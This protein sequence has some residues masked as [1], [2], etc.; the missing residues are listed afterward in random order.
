MPHDHTVPWPA[1]PTHPSNTN[2]RCRL[3]HLVKTFWPGWTD[4]QRPGGTLLIGT[5]SGHTYA[6]KPG[7]ALLF[8]N[9]NTITAAL[10]SPAPGPPLAPGRTLKMPKRKQSRA[11]ARAARM[12][13]ER[14]LNRDGVAERGHLAPY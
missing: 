13:A 3:H 14:A 11:K 7:A 10:P 12:Q 1:G 4:R 6:T 8:P 2:C 5:P 9:V